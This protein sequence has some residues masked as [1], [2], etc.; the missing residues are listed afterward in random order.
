MDDAKRAWD[1][2]GDSFSKL[3][4][5]I[6]EGYRQLEEQRASDSGAASAEG[7]REG[8]VADAIRRATDELDQAFTSLGDTL[9]DD[10][11]QEQLRDTSRKLGDALEVTFT[12]ISEEVRRAVRSRR[13]PNSSEGPPSSPPS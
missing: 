11:T 7:Q 8:V 1:Q 6:S 13:P 5:K 12:A 2:V 9:R 4:R 10:E 3:G